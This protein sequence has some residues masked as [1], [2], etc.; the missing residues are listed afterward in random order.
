MPALFTPDD[1]LA[2]ELVELAEA[3]DDPLWHLPLHADYR[4]LLDSDIADLKNCASEPYAGAV[5]AAL[6]LR[7]FVPQG[8]D[9]VHL[10]FMGWNLRER[11]G[12]PKGGEAQGLL[13]MFAW[14]ER[15]YG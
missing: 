15:R 10:D 6:F 7:E 5:T 3:A 12:H 9:W 1:A 8:V 11:P 2:H 4:Y 13:G 14:L